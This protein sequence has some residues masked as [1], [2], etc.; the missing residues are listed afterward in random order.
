M[1]VQPKVAE[2][3]AAMSVL[4]QMIGGATHPF[5][6]D[7]R[8]F[9]TGWVTLFLLQLFAT[10]SRRVFTRRQ[11]NSPGR[12]WFIWR[13]M[14]WS[15]VKPSANISTDRSSAPNL[16]S[17]GAEYYGDFLVRTI[18]AIHES[19]RINRACGNTGH[20]WA[21]HPRSRT[22]KSASKENHS[23]FTNRGVEEVDVEPQMARQ[24]AMY[25]NPYLRYL[26]L[27]AVVPTP[28]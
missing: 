21:L 26:D 25:C 1:H 23:R 16:H 20:I 15:Y 28:Q 11:F 9:W 10:R 7:G 22:R 5:F 27:K 24:P 6:R 14:N 19:C 8:Y 13:W 17:S 18:G 12:A 2:W 4:V 3:L